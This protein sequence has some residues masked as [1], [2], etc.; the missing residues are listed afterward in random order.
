MRGLKLGWLGT[1]AA[2]GLGMLGTGIAYLITAGKDK[3][4]MEKL[5]YYMNRL[6]ELTD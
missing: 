2:A 1:M 4:A 5:K 6:V 3:L